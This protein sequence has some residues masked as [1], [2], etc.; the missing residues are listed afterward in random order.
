MSWKRRKLVQLVVN[1][2]RVLTLALGKLL[3]GVLTVQ[4]GTTILVELKLGDGNI[5]W[6]NTDIHGGAVALL[7]VHLDHLAFAPTVRT[8][9]DDNLVILADWHGLDVVFAA[10][11]LVKM[12]AHDLA[13]HA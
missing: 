3:G 11:V 9:H 7:A 1:T 5:G 2:L 6:V 8:T 13:S 12:S 4:D 10:E